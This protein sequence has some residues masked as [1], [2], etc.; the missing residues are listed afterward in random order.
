MPNPGVKVGRCFIL[1]LYFLNIDMFPPFKSR[2][3]FLTL[4]NPSELIGGVMRKM[5]PRYL[6][7]RD[8]EA[9]DQTEEFF[10]KFLFC[11]TKIIV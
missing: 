3:S 7:Y 10:F 9:R 6:C 5:A 1:F 11:V 2:L 8:T 4:I